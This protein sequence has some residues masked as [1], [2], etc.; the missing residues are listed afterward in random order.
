MRGANF[1]VKSKVNA[2][3]KKKLQNNSFNKINCSDIQN[4]YLKIR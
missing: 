2:E 4:I 3:S 1:K